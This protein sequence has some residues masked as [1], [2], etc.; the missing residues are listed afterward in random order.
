LTLYKDQ[1]TVQRRSPDNIITYLFHVWHVLT[2]M[3]I[4]GVA[5]DFLPI[6]I[7]IYIYIYTVL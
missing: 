4:F 1:I 2:L 7:Y 6:Y 3:R 5:N